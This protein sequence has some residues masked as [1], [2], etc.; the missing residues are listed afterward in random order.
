MET[1]VQHE[2]DTPEITPYHLSRDYEDH[3]DWL[4]NQRRSRSGGSGARRF[5]RFFSVGASVGTLLTLMLRTV[6]F[7]R[8]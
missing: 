8:G 5:L 1:P 2:R 4:E 7:T 3:L 6:R